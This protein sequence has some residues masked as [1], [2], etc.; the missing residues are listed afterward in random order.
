MQCESTDMYTRPNH[1]CVLHRTA[2]ARARAWMGKSPNV[3]TCLQCATRW[4]ETV[5][6][7]LKLK[8]GRAQG[9]LQA[10][11]FGTTKVRRAMPV[12]VTVP[13]R[14]PVATCTGSSCSYPLC[15]C[16]RCRIALDKQS[17]GGSSRPHV[18]WGRS[19]AARRANAPQAAQSDDIKQRS[20][21]Q[22]CRGA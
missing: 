8:Q 15:T 9:L 16:S 1:T 21:P 12:N 18:P 11:S 5:H 20:C 14:A 19:Q 13:H 3:L 10:A 7:S 2:G 4:L 17:V 22:R 6:M